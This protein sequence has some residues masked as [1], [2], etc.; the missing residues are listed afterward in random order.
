MKTK[1]LIVVRKVNDE[2]ERF[3][4]TH[5]DNFEVQCLCDC[6]DSHGQKI[7]CYNSGCYSFDNSSSNAY[8]DCLED[9]YEHF[10]IKAGYQYENICYSDFEDTLNGENDLLDGIKR[11]D[12]VSFI[13]DWKD[14]NEQHVEVIAWTYWDGS[15]FKTFV[16]DSDSWMTDLEE[17]DMDKQKEILADYPGILD[18]NSAELEVDTECYTF[19]YT[20]YANDPWI[21]SVKEKED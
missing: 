14:E 9:L 1:D 2:D 13:M 11:A 7:G 6:F 4:I 17:L 3:F 21:C 18:I 10:G 12:I 15:N 8:K 19:K 20:R 16:L 5:T